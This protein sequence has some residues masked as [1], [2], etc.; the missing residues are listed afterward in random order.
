MIGWNSSRIADEP[1]VI[2]FVKGTPTLI[3]KSK[4]QAVNESRFGRAEP[5]FGDYALDFGKII[6]GV[7]ELR[8]QGFSSGPVPGGFDLEHRGLQR[9]DG[10]RQVLEADFQATGIFAIRGHFVALPDNGSG[11]H[12]RADLNG[13]K[14]AIGSWGTLSRVHAA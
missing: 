4:L 11:F 14:L 12:K 2:V 3:T 10:R 6:T 13:G 1:E 9:P 5:A 8:L 7:D